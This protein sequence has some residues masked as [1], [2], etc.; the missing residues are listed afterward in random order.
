MYAASVGAHI[1]TYYV[2]GIYRMKLF[3]VIATMCA[4]LISLIINERKFRR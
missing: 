3:Y 2:T 1:F 4:D